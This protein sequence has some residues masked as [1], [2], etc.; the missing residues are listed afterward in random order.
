MTPDGPQA[1]GSLPESSAASS[2]VGQ[3]LDGRFRI[4]RL[5]GEGGM[6]EVY[7]AEHLH[8][9]RR[10]AI[11][12]LKPEIVSNTEAVQR[13]RQEARASSSIGHRNIIKID[14]FVVL[15]DGR[16]Y[17]S[18]ELLTGAPLNEL[19]RNPIP[20][21]RLL[22]IMIQ[23][24]H[25]L[26]AAHAKSI[27]HRDMKPENVF[28][29]VGPEGEDIPKILDF[30]IA[31]VSGNEGQ[32]HL[33]RTGTIFGTPY[34]MAPEQAL[35][36]A[37]DARTDIYAVGVILYECFAGSL[38]FQGESFMGILTQH[39][40]T[41][42]E[43]VAQRAAKAGRTLPDGLAATISRAMQKDP[44]QRFPTMD[45]FV[46]ALID[47]YRGVMGPG[48]TA[49][50]EPASDAS[51][52]RPSTSP[53]PWRPTPAPSMDGGSDGT[54]DA[55]DSAVLAPMRRRG[56]IIA[57]ALLLAVA[58]AIGAV[59]VVGKSSS[60]DAAASD[61]SGGSAS[62]SASASG[63]DPW[64][65]ASPSAA[66]SDVA[67][68]AQSQ[69]VDAPPAVP[70]HNVILDVDPRVSYEV[71]EG[72]T[73]IPDAFLDGLDVLPGEPRTIEIRAEGYKP[74]QVVVT[75]S[76]RRMVVRLE[77]MAESGRRR[78][79]SP[80]PPLPPR[81][82]SDCS[83]QVLDPKSDLCRQQYCAKHPDDGRYGCDIM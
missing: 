82:T 11:K 28:V 76:E 14:D 8:I 49:Y 17:M 54:V 12:L 18:M 2:L 37:V 78:N 35:G 67:L 45:E 69:P 73:K 61:G 16:I 68:D 74:K 66:G 64:G 9:E 3:T 75:G 6:G 77:K 34:Y 55:S 15:G 39:I 23:T 53:L 46:H 57:I 20:P 41:D 43:P 52:D 79:P 33:T 62:A 60:Q 30:G 40:T 38:P 83:R 58:A 10:C 44:A 71:F 1:S 63:S 21:E 13:F 47:V 22:D 25:G 51:G 81:P 42:P 59:V 31:K 36:N 5:I 7:E 24:G 70:A 56:P 80:P 4:V 48:M 26:A 32:N 65:S 50:M 72:Q 29:T 19:I 27:V